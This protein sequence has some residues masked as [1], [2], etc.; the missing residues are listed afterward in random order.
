VLTVEGRADSVERRLAAGEL[1]CPCCA[2]TLARWGYA[3]ERALRG[4]GGT[5]RWLRPRRARCRSCRVTHVLLA[6]FALV[7]RADTAE[8]IGAALV[9]AARG[10]GFRSVAARL[11]VP[12]STVRGWLRCFAR[13][14]GAVQVFF[15]ALAAAAGPDPVMAAAGGSAVADAVAAVAAAGSAVVTRWPQVGQVPVWQAASAASNGLLLAPGWP[16]GSSNTS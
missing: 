1:F 11:G 6:V 15:T 12:A 8:V 13:R 2:G 3:R 14:A 16:A 5:L 7:R 4:P 9:S 10:A